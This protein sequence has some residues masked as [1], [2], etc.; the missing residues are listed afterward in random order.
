M[1][2]GATNSRIIVIGCFV[3]AGRT[4]FQN[5]GSKALICQGGGNVCLADGSVHFFSE[6]VDL[7]TFA[8]LSSMNE[9]EVPGEW[10]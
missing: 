8:E 6:L 10:Q 2:R 9:G 1:Q 4:I 3:V 7:I 5:G